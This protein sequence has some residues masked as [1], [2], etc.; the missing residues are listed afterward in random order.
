TKTRLRSMGLL[1]LTALILTGLLLPVGPQ[2]VLAAG[3]TGFDD[4]L[5]LPNDWKTIGSGVSRTYRFHYA[6][7]GSQLV[8]QVEAEPQDGV[9][10]ELWTPE[11]LR[12]WAAGQ[13]VEPVG[14]GAADPN[15]G[16][17]LWW[18]GS[19]TTPGTYYVIVEHSGT[20]QA[21]NYYN[22]QVSGS[23]VSS[24]APTPAAPPKATPTPKP[25]KT[26][27]PAGKLAFQTS[28]G[29]PIYSISVDGSGLQRL[30]TG[31][32]PAWS[33]DGNQIAF[34]RWQQPRGMWVID[35]DG[36]GERRVFD[37]G[38]TRWPSWSPD[39]SEI[40]F[41]HQ[42]GGREGGEKCFFGFCFTI[43]QTRQW[44]LA[45]V[46]AN[47]G[48]FV[49]PTASKFALGPDFAPDGSLAVYAD[50]QGLRIQNENQSLS[51]LITDDGRD[52]SPM[53]SPDGSQVAFVRRQHDHWEVYV[54]NADGS[55]V[56]RLTDT[57]RKPGGSV[58]DS[59]SPAWS[60]DGN[61]IAFLTNRSGKWEIW[62]MRA[63]GTKPAR[64]FKTALD[65]LTL[66]YSYVGERAISWAE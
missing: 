49:E 17:G 45:V 19:F 9:T 29:G 23:G 54:V 14:R 31:I 4:A 25:K 15:L 24:A 41:S 65:A 39:G 28:F 27:K 10:F 62:R 11:N 2:V 44:H 59:V 61:Y 50:V 26:P 42:K 7:D 3:G 60:P 37:W 6:G 30:T 46:N 32:E 63:D 18:T 5:K 64:M 8:I 20:R 52:N 21:P 56:R 38:E 53:W 33:P 12:E 48:S 34:A 43:P 57:P 16:P 13:K 35:A 55:K 66:D 58:A 47:D 51:Y 1:L 22:L 36:S 40:L